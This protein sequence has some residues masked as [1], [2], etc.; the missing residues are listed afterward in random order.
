MAAPERREVIQTKTFNNSLQAFTPAGYK[1]PSSLLPARWAAIGLLRDSGK[2]LNLTARNQPWRP[3]RTLCLLNPVLPTDAVGLKM[4][5]PLTN[6]LQ[7]P[8]AGADL[9]PAVAAKG[10]EGA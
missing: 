1:A 10:A 9:F 3:V 6:I 7:R 2:Y 8:I 4:T 5:L